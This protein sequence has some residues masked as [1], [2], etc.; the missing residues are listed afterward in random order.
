MIDPLGRRPSLLVLTEAG[1]R[2][3]A[4]RVRPGGC[5]SALPDALSYSYARC[6]RVDRA[7]VS[8]P[9]EGRR[10]R[11]R[12]ST[13]TNRLPGPRDASREREVGSVPCV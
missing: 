5:S 4:E 10:T 2:H 12:A 1:W 8:T 7:R 13:S 6:T 3:S 9:P 11:A